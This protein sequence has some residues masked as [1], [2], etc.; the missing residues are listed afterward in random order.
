[1]FWFV[2]SLGVLRKRSARKES[3]WDLR[4]PGIT[5]AGDFSKSCTWLRKSIFM[6]TLWS[7]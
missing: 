5:G 2:R 1:M 7:R 3:W 4:E 6:I